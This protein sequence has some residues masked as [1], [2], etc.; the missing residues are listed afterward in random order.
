MGICLSS[1]EML[2][3]LQDRKVNMVRCFYKNVI[4][5]QTLGLP[6]RCSLIIVWMNSNWNVVNFRHRMT[7]PKEAYEL[8]TLTCL[9]ILEGQNSSIF[10]CDTLRNKP[11]T[12]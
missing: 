4:G 1:S 12:T 10:I 11:S 7:G 6:L 2:I 3:I 8:I 5:G 9:Y